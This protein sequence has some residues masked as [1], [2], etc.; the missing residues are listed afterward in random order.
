VDSDLR[1]ELVRADPLKLSTLLLG[2][3][4]NGA[5][6]AKLLF[7][8]SDPAVVA[9]LEV[10]GA[11]AGQV[12]ASIDLL[13]SPEGTA[14]AS[15]PATIT[16][17]KT[18]DLRV[19]YGGFTIRALQPGDYVVRMSVALDGQRVGQVIR[20]MRKEGGVRR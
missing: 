8:E 16:A 14:I 1:A 18:G 13:P 2:I 9:Y 4:V 19:A 20:T 7:G 17:S 3:P 6:G 5:F 10:Y 15:V 12:A 11:V